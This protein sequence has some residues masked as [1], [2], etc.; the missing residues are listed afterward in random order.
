MREKPLIVVADDDKDFREVVATK[1]KKAGFDVVE[2]KDGNEAFAQ[3]KKLSPDLVLLDINMPPGP[4]GI[5]TALK[6]KGTPE[7]KDLKIIFLSGL[8]DPW[9]AFVGTKQEVSRELGMLD[10]FVKT[11]DFSELVKKVQEIVQGSEKPVEASGGN[12]PVPP[13]IP[14]TPP[15]P[16]IVPRPP[17]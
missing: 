3:A 9:P 4:S 14:L 11:K 16:L 2:V 10:F 17:Q 6:L 12:P 8:D 7:T 5:E 1:L 13:P 15:E